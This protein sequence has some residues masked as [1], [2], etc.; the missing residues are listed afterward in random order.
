M[1]DKVNPDPDR[2]DNDR[3]VETRLCTKPTPVPDTNRTDLTRLE[4]KFLNI[5]ILEHEVAQ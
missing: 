4:N 1:D 2:T 3:H 5:D